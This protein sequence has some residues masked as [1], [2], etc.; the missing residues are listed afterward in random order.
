MAAT[1]ALSA[2][3]AWINDGLVAHYKFDGDAVD[4]SE[5]GNDGSAE[6][7]LWVSDRFGVE[8]SALYTSR[9][10]NNEVR[11]SGNDLPLGSDPRTF[12]VWIKPDSKAL[13]DGEGLRGDIFGYGLLTGGDGSVIPHINWVPDPAGALRLVL[14]TDN[15]HWEQVVVGW[16]F[17][18]WHHVA[19]VYDGGALARLYVDG[20]LMPTSIMAGA[21]KSVDE[22]SL[23]TVIGP[24]IIGHFADYY[25]DGAIDDLRIYDRSLSPAEITALH[26]YE[27][28]LIQ[29]G[30]EEAGDPRD[31]Y[32]LILGDFTWNQARNDAERRGGYLATITS[33]EEQMEISQLVR[34]VGV[35]WLGASDAREEGAWEWVTG[36]AFTFE[37]WSPGE[38]NNCC[39]GEDYLELTG[40]SFWND[41][42]G[43]TR[44]VGYILETGPPL[45]KL[46]NSFLR[47]DGAGDYVV[48]PSLRD[49]SGDALSIQYWFRGE[50]HTS[51]VRQQSGENF[52][53][54]G[55][56]GKHLLSN[57]GGTD[58]IAAG[59]VTDGNWHHVFLT[60]SIG[61]GSFFAS[62]LDG[63]LVQELTGGS[64]G[65]PRIGSITVFGSLLGQSEFLK[66]D[67]DEIAIWRRGF[68]HEEIVQRW[69]R[70]LSGEEDGLEG[71][72]PFNNG[73]VNDASPNEHHGI[74]RG[75]AR[76]VESSIPNTVV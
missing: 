37:K 6:R 4:S 76:V 10:L 43:G 2:Q 66:G 47:L 45:N 65:I 72:W 26:A 57:E 61:S 9:D 27:K 69:Y 63:R 22:L 13:A 18:Q 55:W 49:L 8:D 41:V 5:S 25:F 21:D 20:L 11:A 50:D 19:W 75:D 59:N 12:S 71:Y 56:N 40:D 14:G 68:S 39:G 42:P 15:F 46:E 62:Y 48:V 74:I 23:D 53:V 35:Y 58:G 16:D 64:S 3:P 33:E 73:T 60:W 31:R 36:E 44:S 67:L 30:G 1:F 24:L 28:T 38:P 51:A 70:K 52:I 34:P 7:P 54:A 29:P 17:D 32:N